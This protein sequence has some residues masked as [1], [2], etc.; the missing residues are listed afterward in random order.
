MKDLH[1]K[2]PVITGAA[3]GIGRGIAEAFM[4]AGFKLVLS[5]VEQGALNATTLE[6]RNQ[7]AD[8]SRAEDIS[9]LAERT[10][11][12]YGA[13]HVLCNNAGVYAGS[14]PSWQSTLDDWNWIVGVNLMGVVHGIQTFMPLLIEQD[15][16]VHIVNTSS[17]AGL[18]NSGGTL[19]RTTKTA[20]VALS[21]SLQ[22]EL[23]RDAKKIKISVLCP[24][25]VDTNL[26]YS[27]RNRPSHFPKTGPQANNR[28]IQKTK[29]AFKEGNQPLAIG[30]QVVQAIYDER[31]YIL[32]NPE[33]MDHIKHR[34]NQ[35]VSGE[36]PTPLPPTRRQGDKALKNQT[37]KID[38]E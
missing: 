6:L 16:E 1:N 27:D 25:L 3:S 30:N 32:P 34:A 8:V 35:I 28:S 37:R 4:A 36:N 22:Q 12:E 19:Y 5:D 10:L 20:I 26:L 9:K 15:E 24:A 23:E 11:E 7:G 14:M 31:F 33:W 13:V 29:Q 17:I 18:I 21:E 2:V 38:S